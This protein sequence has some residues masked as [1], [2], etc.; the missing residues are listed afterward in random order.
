MKKEEFC[1]LLSELKDEHI[2]EAESYRVHRKKAVWLRVG[3]IAA[4]LCVLLAL[5]LPL[6]HQEE[7]EAPSAD[8]ADVAPHVILGD[9]TYIVSSYLAMSEELPEGFSYAGTVSLYGEEGH[10]YYTNPDCPEWIYIRQEMRYDGTQDEHGALLQTEP[11][12][13]YVRYVDSTIR[14]RDFV[15]YNGALYVSMWSVS[16]TESPQLYARAEETYGIRIEGEAPDGFLSAGT[17]EFSGHDTLPK[18]TLSSNTGT[19]E[20]YADPDD[21]E[22]LLVSTKWHIAPDETGE[23][24]HR[25]FNVY[26]LCP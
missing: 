25:G 11:H 10:A 23:S 20:V 18:G 5:F 14:G 7:P 6:V 8:A 4:C 9:T 22:V 1:A 3:A 2:Q 21:P 24:L 13:E 17:A 26:I 12:M 19:E 16:P 15:S